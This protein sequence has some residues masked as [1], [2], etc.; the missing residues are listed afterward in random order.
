MNKDELALF[1]N[2]GVES[3]QKKYRCYFEFGGEVSSVDT[4][5]LCDKEAKIEIAKSRGCNGC[6][7]E[8]TTLRH[9]Y[10][11]KKIYGI[12]IVNWEPIL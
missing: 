5:L 12:E 1:P 4:F 8:E 6:C 9:F 11:L 7:T 2:T 10:L 3:R